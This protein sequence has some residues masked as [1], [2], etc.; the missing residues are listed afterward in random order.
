MLTMMG[1]VMQMGLEKVRQIFL[2]VLN[3]EFPNEVGGHVKEP[4]MC[5][6]GNCIHDFE[7]CHSS[8]S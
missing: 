1:L 6:I 2:N 3:M 8:F 5:K 7:H 4:K